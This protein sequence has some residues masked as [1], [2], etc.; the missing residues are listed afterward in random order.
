M[1]ADEVVLPGVAE[2][3]LPAERIAVSVVA[4]QAND[5]EPLSENTVLVCALA[6]LRLLGK[7]DWTKDGD[8]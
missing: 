6:L 3:L 1:T 8:R 2:F 7:H 4:R 5:N